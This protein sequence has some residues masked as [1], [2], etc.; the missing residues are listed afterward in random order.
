MDHYEALETRFEEQWLFPS[1][2]FNTSGTIIGWRFASVD[3]TGKG[4]PRLSVWSPDLPGSDTY[5]FRDSLL[6][7]QCTT[8]EV[9]LGDGET[10]R[11]HFG[12]PLPGREGLSFSEGDI[13]GVL[14]RAESVAALVPYLYN[15]SIVNPFRDQIDRELLGYFLTTRGERPVL[16]LQNLKSAPMLPMLA[17]DLCKF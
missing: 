14:F 1:I 17:L 10:A 5:V 16:S 8:S 2:R 13:I 3:H 9:T 11:F 6:M 12:G 7:H 15:T 4:T